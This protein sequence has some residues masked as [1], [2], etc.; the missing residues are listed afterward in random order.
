MAT[1]LG[2]MISAAELNDADVANAHRLIARHAA[3]DGGERCS[4]CGQVSP[5]LP[6][7]IAETMLRI[8]AER[9]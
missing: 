6:R 5:C 4:V 9:Q 2:A 3:G 1:K 7:R 8:A